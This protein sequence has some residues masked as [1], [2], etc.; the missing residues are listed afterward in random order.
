MR[1]ASTIN[2]VSSNVV[3]IVVSLCANRILRLRAPSN[4][5]SV[6]AGGDGNYCG[7]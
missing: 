1:D 2:K 5:G 3:I 4:A 6:G 7:R